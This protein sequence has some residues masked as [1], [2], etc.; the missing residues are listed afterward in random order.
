MKKLTTKTSDEEYVDKSRKEKRSEMITVRV[1]R[2]VFMSPE[3]ISALDQC[4]TSDYSVMRT[5]SKLF[6]QFETQDG[7]RIKLTDFVMSQVS[8]PQE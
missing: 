4:K 3:L 6:K 5:F 2:N 1:P 8:A 7:K